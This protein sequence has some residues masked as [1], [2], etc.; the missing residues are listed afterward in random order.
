MAKKYRYIVVIDTEFVSSKEGAQPFQVSLIAY[1]IKDDE[2]VKISDFN[3]F[4]MLKEGLKLNYYARKY[5]GITYEKLRHEGIY[6]NMAIQQVINFLLMFNVDETL[7]VGW[8]PN[9]D[10]RMLDHLLN[11]EDGL[12]NLSAFDWYDV[13]KTYCVFNN[14]DPYQTPSFEVAAE[15][16]NL[17]NYK[18]HDSMED[19]TATA[20]LLKILIKEHGI[21]K[22]IYKTKEAKESKK[23]IKKAR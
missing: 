10:K 21:E 7:I 1:E 3:V 6:P 11:D 13:A 18:F 22:V 15:K 17:L 4:I 8:A 9:N 2:L 20:E 16:Y 23:R 19:A 5:T 14:L 12:I